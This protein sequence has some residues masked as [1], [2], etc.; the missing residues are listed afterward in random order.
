MAQRM[1]CLFDTVGYIIVMLLGNAVV[2]VLG[3]CNVF[4]RRW[5]H[6]YKVT[7]ESVMSIT[8]LSFCLICEKYFLVSD[9][10]V[11]NVNNTVLLIMYIIKVTASILIAFLKKRKK[12]FSP[13]TK[14][15][16]KSDEITR[17]TN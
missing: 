7:N 16:G 9:I 14:V 12:C 11:R 13:Q 8:N 3:Q 10:T 15:K 1:T 2:M 17:F 4:T 5:L 6:K